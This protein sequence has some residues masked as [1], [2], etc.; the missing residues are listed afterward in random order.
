[1]TAKFRPYMTIADIDLTL[2]C[3]KE[4]PTPARL[5]LAKY[6]EVFKLKAESG[7]TQAAHRV[8]PTLDQRLG[9]SEPPGLS[10][11]TQKLMAW[12]KSYDPTKTMTARDIELA[13]LYKYEN[14]LMTPEEITHYEAIFTRT[15]DSQPEPGDI[16]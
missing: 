11:D 5:G 7:L 10:L 13:Q 16:T 3:L 2:E 14:D 12:N 4:R 8:Q 6:F 15:S 1:M 9:F